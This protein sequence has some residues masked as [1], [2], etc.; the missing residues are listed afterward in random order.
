MCDEWPAVSF[1]EDWDQGAAYDGVF[2]PGMTICIESYLGAAG[3]ADG[4]KLEEQVLV[5]ESGA[6]RLSTFPYEDDIF[7]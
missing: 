1:V 4:I 5:T 3:G 6:V 7:G 2:E